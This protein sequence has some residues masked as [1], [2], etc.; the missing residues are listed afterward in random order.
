MTPLPIESFDL[1]DVAEQ[2]TL[3]VGPHGHDVAAYSRCSGSL[4][5]CDLYTS[6]FVTGREQR[7]AV[8]SAHGALTN[9]T[10]SGNRVAYNFDPRGLDLSSKRFG[11]FWSRLDQRRRH[12]VA[13]MP[14]DIGVYLPTL[15]L[16]GRRLAY[17][18]YSAINSCLDQSQVRV[19]NLGAKRGFGQLIAKGSDRTDVFSPHWSGGSLYFGRDRFTKRS[20]RH[21]FLAHQI[22]KSR[23]ERHVAGSSGNEVT[24]YGRAAMRE[25]LPAGDALLFYAVARKRSPAGVYDAGTPAFRKVSSPG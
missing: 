3:G 8:S 24:R 16:S 17:S 2:A 14:F 12:R 1:P 19:A 9:P 13:T 23:I 6:D 5:D 7:L 15:A 25:V 4:R 20:Y 22:A 21:D 18:G 10:V 11:V